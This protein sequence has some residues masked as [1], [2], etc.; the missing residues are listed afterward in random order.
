MVRTQIIAQGP[1]S[2]DKVKNMSR[3][4]KQLNLFGNRNKAM[5]TCRFSHSQRYRYFFTNTKENYGWNIAFS[6]AAAGCQPK[7]FLTFLTFFLMVKPF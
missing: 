5:F 3:V 1:N 7:T 6:F 4:L 2:P